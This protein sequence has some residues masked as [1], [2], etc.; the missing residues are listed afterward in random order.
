MTVSREQLLK[1]LPNY[2]G[3]WFTVKGQQHVNDI[4][5]D[6][7]IC[8]REF[9]SHYDIIGPAFADVDLYSTCERLYNFCSDNIWYEEETED[10]QTTAI[11]AGILVRGHGDC[12]HYASFI[13]GCL[14]AIGRYEGKKID[15]EYCFAS[16]KKDQ[17]TPYHV[18]V[19]VRDV[20]GS[21]IWID[22][23]PGATGRDPV[24]WLRVKP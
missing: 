23:T 14:D 22:P 7:L 3:Q 19:I 9:R 6:I 17:R 20:D 10:C 2:R 15:F 13:A 18:F 4:I 8:H 16:Y 11:P 24:Y 12:K 1:E 21:E 5:N